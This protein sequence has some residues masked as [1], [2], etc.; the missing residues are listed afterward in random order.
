MHERRHALAKR[1]WGAFRQDFG[2]APEI[3]RTGFEGF[4]SQSGRGAAQIVSREQRLP[5][6]A[7]MLFDGRVKFLATGRALEFGDV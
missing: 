2:I 3:T 1:D 6:T 7:E 4:Q 5:A